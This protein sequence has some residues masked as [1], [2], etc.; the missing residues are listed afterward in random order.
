MSDVIETNWVVIHSEIAPKLNFACHQSAFALVRDL[1]I[2]NQDTEE[3]LDDVLVTLTSDPAFIKPKSWTVDRIAPEGLVSVG[4]LDIDFEGEFLLNLTDAVRGSLTTRVEKDGLVLAEQTTHV[5]L[6][7][8]NEWGGSGFMPELL[9]AFSLPN[10]PAVDGIL[11]DASLVLRRAGKKDSLDGYESGSR[12]R[13]WEIVSAIY[14]AIANLGISYAVPPAS[15]ERD[16]QKIRFPSQILEN[17]VATC[18]DTTMLF[19]SAFEQ[20]GLNPIIAM[21]HGHA[22]A[23]VWL[24]PEELSSIVI[25]EAETLRKRIQLKELILIESTLVTSHPAPP[26]SKA[27]AAGRATIEPDKDESFSAAVDVRRARAHRISPLGI[28]TGGAESSPRDG[29]EPKVELSFEE[30]PPLPDF[31]EEPEEEMAETAVGRLERWQR[32]LLDLTARNPLLNH[33]STKTSLR[34]ICPDP[35]ALEDKLAAGVRMSIH[36]LPKP[37]SQGQDE[38]LHRQRTGEVITDEYASDALERRQVLVD[39][40]EDELSRRA[41]EIYRKAQTA[42]QEG[43]ANTLY[44][45][46]GFLLWKRDT[47][48]ERRFRA[49]LILMPISLERKS[50]R[51]GVRMVAHD[52]EPRFNT[53]LLE[54]LRRDFE[55][56]I[57]GLGNELPTDESGVDVDQIWNLVRHAVKEA[58]GFEV[59]EDVAIGHFSFAKYLMWKDLVD[60]TDALRENSVVRHLLDSPRDPYPTGIPF[61][62]GDQ[63][64]RDYKPSDLLVPLPADASQMAAIATADRGKDFIIIGPPGTGK[65]QTIS[66]LIAHFLGKGKTVLFVSEKTAALEVVYRRLDDIGLGRFCLQLHSN[67]ARKADVLD[68]LRLAW[69]G[70]KTKTADAWR[71]EAENLQ[72]LRDRLN[73]YVDHLHRRHDNGL[74]PHYAIGVKVRDEALAGRL[75]FSWPSA[76]QHDEQRLSDM[77]DAVE[78]LSIQVRAVKNITDSPFQIVTQGDWSPNWENQVVERAGRL[79][80]ATAVADRECTALLDA[81][82]ISVPDRSLKRLDALEELVSV[83]EASYREETAYSLEPD[84]QELIEAFEDAF[85]RLKSYAEKQAALSCKYDPMAWRNLDGEEIDQ[86]WA[87]AEVSWWPKSF[88]LRRRV[89]KDM[90][91]GG[92]LGKPSPAE[93]ATILAGLRLDGETLDRL[94]I[95]LTGIREWKAH[96]TPPEVAEKLQ[97]LGQRA[98][99]TVAKLAD[100]SQELIE[101]RSKIRALLLEGNDL[102]APGAV[103]HRSATAFR[104]ALAEFRTACASFETVGGQSVRDEFVE[105]GRALDVIRETVD[106]IHARH[107]ELRE[108]CG[109]H[110]RRTEAIDLDLGPLVDAIEGGRVPQDEILETFEA[111]YCTWWSGAIIGED[112]ILRTFSSP[113]QAATIEKFR[114]VDDRFQALTAEYVTAKL[115]GSLPEAEDVTKNSEWGILRRELQKKQRHKPVRQLVKEVPQVLTTLAPCMMMS[116]LSVAQYLPADQAMFDVVI[117]DEASQIT[118]WDAVGALARGRQAIVAGDPKQMPPTNFFNRS[119]DDPDGDI[120]NEGDLESILDEMRGA[121]IPERTLNLHYRSRRESLIAFS[122]NRYYDNSL[123]T[124]PAPVNPDRGVRLVRPE[125]AYSRGKSRTNRG[126]AQA[127]VDE[128]LR[129]L[130]HSD[131]VVREMS[132]GVV[133]FNSEQQNLI[134]NLLDNARAKDPEIEW[135]FSSDSTLEPVFVKNLETVQGDERDIILFSIAY[136]PDEAGHMTMNFGPLN[137]E[138]GERRLNVAMTRARYEMIVFSVL[139]PEQIDLSRTQAKAVTDLKHFLEYAERGHSALAAAVHGSIGDFESPFE[140]AV[141]RSLRDLGWEVHPQIGV[142]AYRID[143]GIVHPDEPGVYLAGVECDGAMYHSSAF[144]R[145]RDKIREAVLRGLGWTLSRVWSTDWWTNRAQ[146]LDRLD[147]QLK[148]LLEADRERRVAENSDEEGKVDPVQDDAEDVH[149]LEEDASSPEDESVIANRADLGQGQKLD[150]VTA[151]PE[152]AISVPDAAKAPSQS[153]NDD[154]EPDASPSS[155]VYAAPGLATFEPNSDRFYDDDYAPKLKAMIDHVIETEGPIH[156]DVLVRRVARHHEFQRAGRQIREIVIKFAKTLRRHTAENVGLFFWPKGAVEDRISPARSEDR[157]DEM[158]KIEYICA[159]ELRAINSALSLGGDPVGLARS[160]GIA[161]LSEAARERLVDV[162]DPGHAG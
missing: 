73:S 99:V 151:E 35:G 121:S 161:R 50:V 31:D 114:E 45:A 32:K 27:E 43:G 79:S 9:A 55:I 26:F 64:D 86:R 1:T 144:A 41:V 71:R 23:G 134:E 111:A 104:D 72:T 130:T 102:L 20:A 58:P 57:K 78:R 85:I 56:D 137:R 91:A 145:E 123:I 15:F 48:D 107:A 133:T 159:E 96:N 28:K 113:E 157:N 24:Q 12:Q 75:T 112:E 103:V 148:A 17:R 3:R 39:L 38:T 106:T 119:D 7:A 124:F 136:G 16:G 82:G 37:T 90:R 143:L 22:V 142:S 97:A 61:V 21:P 42:L 49:P 53:T 63:L 110:R 67:K 155:Y 6:L 66:N 92:A 74:T 29:D 65:S 117:F 33:K 87:A 158:R 131:S 18:L 69:G 76:Q 146:S 4:N 51:S 59:V 70:I 139:R 101:A 122:N 30:A 156:E 2:K 135:A 100:D 40:P 13:V 34:L 44:L 89:I 62:E 60:R 98:R 162:L 129:R 154:P 132:I 83:L 14:T 94:D 88:F 54:M 150:H 108:W 8:Y 109:W 140:I 11:R 68:Q 52:D 147:E 84:G 118:V 120:D 81:V 19:A 152:T 5:E 153:Y 46:L 160:L 10:D 138:G 47:K 93:D 105:T 80:A 128:I 116:P 125:G 95:I 77:R 127:I 115:G 141:A 126:E 149:E 25:D 36:P